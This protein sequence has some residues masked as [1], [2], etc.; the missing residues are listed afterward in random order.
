MTAS[1]AAWPRTATSCRGCGDGR[2]DGDC[3]AG[4][5]TLAVVLAQPL[6]IDHDQRWAVQDQ[7]IGAGCWP[8]LGTGAL[9]YPED[10]D[11]LPVAECAKRMAI[12][13]QRVRDLVERRA[14][15]STF[16]WGQLHVEPAIVN[17]TT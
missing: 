9:M 7:G 11:W 17:A 15:R 4:G 3:R 10:R 16:I 2:R 6:G 13:E 1:A 14:L 8:P 5:E 12:T